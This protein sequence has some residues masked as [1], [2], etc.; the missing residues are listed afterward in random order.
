MTRDLRIHQSGLF[1]WITIGSLMVLAIICTLIFS[2]KANAHGYVEG[3]SSRAYLCK[4]GQNTNCGA[5]IYEPQSLEALKGFPAAGPADGQIASANGAFPLLDQ[6][7]STRWTKVNISSGQNTFYWK[8]TAAHATTSWKYYITKQNWNPDAALTRDSFDLTPFCSVSHGGTRPPFNYSDTCNVPSRTGYQVI[9]AVW[10]IADTPNAFYNVIDVNFGN[11][12]DTTAPTA[13]SP[14]SVSGTTSTTATLSWG[15]STDAYGVTQYRI[16]NGSTLVN[17]VAGSNLTYTVTGLSPSTSYSYHVVALDA[18]GNISPASATVIATT[19]API[20]DTTPPT[21]PSGLHVMGTP[22][23]N[24]LQLMWSPS[25]DNIGVDSYKIYQGSAL[26]VVVTGNQTSFN[27][28][29][30]TP[31]TTYSFTVYALDAAGN[32]S[33]VSNSISGTTAAPPAVQAWAP[34][35]AYAVNTLVSYN[36]AIY[37]CRQTHTSLAGWTPTAVPALWLLQP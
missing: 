25:T 16:Y 19:T 24:S 26:L 3:P 8:L 32:Q 34:N 35:T 7:S 23:S 6:Q 33:A 15:A 27:V 17:S 11:S 30:L 14:I 1:K 29:G 31:S 13:P 12:N 28:S 18:A 10:E 4:L 37:K 9:L 21:A 22:T 2:E 20:I 36:G 5:I